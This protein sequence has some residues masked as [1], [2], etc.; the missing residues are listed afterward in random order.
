MCGQHGNTRVVILPTRGS[1]Y[2]YIF[3][4]ELEKLELKYEI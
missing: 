3:V 1:L 4:T 2:F